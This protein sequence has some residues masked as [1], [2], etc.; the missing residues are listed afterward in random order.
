MSA[1]EGPELTMPSW[2]SSTLGYISGTDDQAFQK[3]LPVCDFLG[4]Y[5]SGLG[6]DLT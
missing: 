6:R 1:S 2:L 3:L 5:L 4:H